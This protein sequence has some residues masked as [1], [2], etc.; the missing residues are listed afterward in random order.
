MQKKKEISLVSVLFMILVIFIHISS[1]CIKNYE[2]SSA[3]F[4]VFSSLNRLSSF[5]VQGFIFLSGLKLFINYK[6]EFSYGKFCLSRL[7]RVVLPYFIIFNIF[8]IFMAVMHFFENP[9]ISHYLKNFFLGD[10]V[11]HFYFVIIICQFY[12]LIPLWRFL[13]KK[14]PAIPALL[15]SLLIMIMS[16][17]AIPELS[18]LLFKTEF[19]YNDT[20]FTT[21]IFYFVA[22]IYAAKYYDSFIERITKSK[23][24]I[25][26]L[27][28]IAGLADA[29]LLYMIRLNIYYPQWIENL[30]IAYSTLAIVLSLAFM[31]SLR[32]WKFANTKTFSRIDKASYLIYLIHPIFIFTIDIIT[33]PMESVMIRFILRFLF[34]YILS[35]GL[36]LLIQ[37]FFEKIKPGMKK[38]RNE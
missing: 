13:Y 20:L 37:I 38:Q 4:I 25:A 29:A 7:K 9:S 17:V 22:G 3:G 30:H 23:T 24:A 28:L 21:Y 18:R 35:I 31:Y 16:K 33:S 12:I 1:D 15:A 26:I 27:W 2:V 11:S 32:E 5:V 14:V 6:E 19:L 8:Y 34:T 10:L 36:G